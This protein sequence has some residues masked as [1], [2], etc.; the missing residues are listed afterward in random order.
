MSPEDVAGVQ[1]GM[2]ERPDSVATLATINVTT[3]IIAGGED[4]V[5]LSEFELMR[6]GIAGS[7][8]RVISR[9]GHYAALEKTDEFGWLLRGFLDAVA[10]RQ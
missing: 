7:E 8:L 1:R 2:A 3:L 5:P 4:S 9:A 6:Q 10:S